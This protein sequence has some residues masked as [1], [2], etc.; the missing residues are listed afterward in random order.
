MMNQELKPCPFCGS[1]HILFREQVGAY[2]I[3]C[4][5]CDASAG[6][7]KTF[8]DAAEAWNRRESKG[9]KNDSCD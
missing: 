1:N 2:E 5:E 3:Y 7:R 6:I 8:E 4:P 9:E